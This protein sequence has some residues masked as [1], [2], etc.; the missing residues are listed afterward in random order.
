MRDAFAEI[1]RA[2]AAL[3]SIDAGTDRETWV[4][5]AM[6]AKS[7]GLD[8]DTWHEWS[9]TAGNYKN[10]A[11]CRSVWQSIK[12]GPV[13][14]GSLFHAA[15]A[16]GWSDD[17]GAPAV[18]P[19]SHQERPKQPEATKPPPYDPRVLWD[20]CVPATAE[21]PYVIKKL[22]LPDGLRV[23]RGSMTI[24]GKPCNGAL[25]LP[26]RTLD[27][28]LASLQFI[29]PDGKKLFLPCRKLPHDG[30]LIIGGPIRE[31]CP[32]YVGEGVGQAWSA[33][34]AT[35]APAVCCFGIGRMAGVAKALHERYPAARLVL[36]ADAG[37]ENQCAA[38]A[39]DVHGACVE[40]P[41]G[42]PSNFDLNDFHQAHDLK[43]VAALLERVKAPTSRFKLSERTADRLFIGEPPPVNWLVRRIFPLGVCCL[44]A[45]PPNVGKSFLSLELAAKMA[46]WPG[47]D[48]DYS[49]GAEVAAH[50][51]AVYVSAEDDEPEIHRRLWS[52][53]NGRMP[54][55]LH[56]LSLPDVGH[57]G[58]IEVDRVTKE[59]RPTEAWRDLVAEIRELPDV[60][61]ILL[62][63]LQA[64]TTGD[65]NTVEA[66]QPLMNECTALASA[67]GACVMLLHHV[68]KGST[69]EIRTALDALECIRG[70]GAIIGSA[71]AAYVMWPP[72][73]GGKAI[74][75][76]LGEQYQEGKVAHG[77]LA[78]KYGDG[79]RDRSVFVRD[80]RGI[81][82]DRTKQYT[83]LSGAADDSEAL[84]DGLATGIR[85]QW[86]AGA[87]FAASNGSNGLHARRFELPEMF[88]DKPRAWFD[89]TIALLLAEARI[90]RMPYQG[91]KRYC[92][93]EAAAA[94]PKH[95]P[96]EAE[97]DAPEA[98]E[99]APEEA[100]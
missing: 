100:A 7:A 43:P 85:E 82:R 53:C 21:Q 28:D 5:I 1:E 37:K 59:Y 56:V 86:Q 79:R 95:A 78:K 58:I 44:V 10:E 60:K 34:Q 26:C 25:V 35:R 61:L 22:G 88:H 42:S 17:E 87:S 83:A 40:M 91:G 20:A 45:S 94:I 64:L 49:F 81:L 80:E 98:E 66:T 30:C 65:T 99:S 51:R 93:P 76:V 15:R 57:F 62:D 50:G 31:G 3:W 84:R 90:K 68:A 54:D 27:G 38:I 89:K 71:R 4:K 52:L 70:S 24:S 96:T 69:K 11:D 2:R 39:K 48:S 12:P 16:A 41:E 47:P 32:V 29:M 9:A 67:T 77:I 92:P 33:H 97:N 74:C 14:E 63:T 6:A 8:F 13:G 72:A 73:D 19:Q 46:G 36:V 75:D 18:R 55:R 23:Y